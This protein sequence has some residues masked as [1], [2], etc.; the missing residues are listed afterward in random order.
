[1]R[2]QR[3]VVTVADENLGMGGDFLELQRAQKVIRTIAVA[4]AKNRTHVIAYEHFFQF[5]R[6]PLQR[7]GEI[8][9]L[10]ED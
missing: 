1:M 10:V 8:Q 9:I 2:Q 5:A 4:S 7:S 6:P 3:G